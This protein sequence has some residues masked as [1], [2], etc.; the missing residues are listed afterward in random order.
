MAL[1][2]HYTCQTISECIGIEIH[3]VC[4]PFNLLRINL[5]NRKISTLQPS[6]D[7]Q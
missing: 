5:K 4:W 3:K 7:H 1:Q 2:T 6:F